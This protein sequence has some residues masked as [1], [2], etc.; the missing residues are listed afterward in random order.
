MDAT[1]KQSMA[2]KKVLAEQTRD[3]NSLSAEDSIGRIPDLLRL[4]QL[5]IESLSKRCKFS[6]SSFSRLVSL[7]AP[8]PDPATLISTG[9]DS[10]DELRSTIQ[11]LE[12]EL[13]MLK[14]QD[15]TVRRL[16]K[17]VAELEAQKRSEFSALESEWSGRFSALRSEHEQLVRSLDERMGKKSIELQQLQEDFGSSRQSFSSEISRLT[18][19]I[20]G[21]DVEIEE[22]NRQLDQTREELVS[23]RSSQAS[24]DRVDM[25]K[26]YYERSELRVRQ[27]EAELVSAKSTMEELTTLKE[28][29]ESAERSQLVIREEKLSLQE[30]VDALTTTI[31]EIAAR[32]LGQDIS[33]DLHVIPGAVLSQFDV[34]SASRDAALSEQARLEHVIG[35]L[36]QAIHDKDS[37]LLKFSTGTEDNGGQVNS[38]LNSQKERLRIRV[39][40][41]E[42]E[43]DGLK[44]AQSE[45]SHRI[46]QMSSD[47]KKLEADRNYWRT[48]SLANQGTGDVELGDMKTAP[49]LFRKKLHAAVSSGSHQQIEQSF[50]S[51][52]SYGLTNPI[53]R[54]AGLVY[55]LTLHL[56]VFMVLYRLSSLVSSP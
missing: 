47:N 30:N 2:T 43:R 27:L 25:Y 48:Q 34:L 26:E 35:S 11:E 19:V 3:F 32:I 42:N 41:L 33:S 23:I 46:S 1:K 52:V 9:T 6:E 12:R 55:L 37:E 29:L 56:L 4:Y 13:G 40:E 51:L 24:I 7:L 20:K 22:L 14:N 31:R 17:R 28:S 54:R 15:L 21:K 36:N 8:L 44:Q 50:V 16:E 38:M 45:L 10:T 18:D 5:E 49:N 53:L 39:L